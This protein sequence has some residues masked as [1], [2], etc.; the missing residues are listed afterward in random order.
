M[1]YKTLYREGT[2]SETFEKSK[3]IGHAKPVSSKE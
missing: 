3:F 2:F 1:E